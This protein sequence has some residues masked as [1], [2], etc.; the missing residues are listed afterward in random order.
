MTNYDILRNKVYAGL[1]KRYGEITKEIQ[2][3]TDYEL[4][5][6]HDMGFD[7]Y[8]LILDRVRNTCIDKEYIKDF[9][10]RKGFKVPKT[11]YINMSIFGRGSGIGTMIAYGLNLS[12][13]DPIKYDLYFDRFLNKERVSMPDFDY[14][15]SR[16]DRQLLI[17]VLN[18][19]FPYVANIGTT[20][21]MGVK[22]CIKDIG[23]VLGVP[24]QYTNSV[25]KKLSDTDGYE[26]FLNNESV[27]SEFLNIPNVDH[28]FYLKAIQRINGLGK[29]NGIHAGGIVLCGE[30]ISSYI[31][32]RF[33]GER[34]ITEVDMH[35]VE[36]VGFVKNDFLGL[37]TLDVLSECEMVT[38]VSCFD[39][40]QNFDDVDVYYDLRNGKTLGVFQFEGD[41][42]TKLLKDFNVSNFEDLALCNALYR[43]SGLDNVFD[44]KTMLQHAIDRK[45]KKEAIIYLFPEEEQYLSYTYGLMVYQEQIMRRVQQMTGCSLGKADIFRR[46]VGKKD[47]KLLAEQLDWFVDKAMNYRF[48]NSSTWDNETWRKQIVLQVMEDIKACGRYCFN[49]SHAC[50][51]SAI[52]Y[53][54]AYYAHYYPEVFYSAMLNYEDNKDGLTMELAKLKT[55]GFII[56]SPNVNKSELDFT[57]LGHHTI[58]FGLASIKNM[59]KSAEAILEDR[60]KR[61]E[62]SSLYDFAFRL[63]PSECDK[64]TLVSL[65]KAGAFDTICNMDRCS[66]VASMDNFCKMR[67]NRMKVFHRKA[68][69]YRAT[70]EELIDMVNRN[71]KKIKYEEVYDEDTATKRAYFENEVLGYF[72][73]CTPLDD[74]KQEMKYYNCAI[75]EPDHIPPEAYYVGIISSVREITIKNGRS[76]GKKMC[77][78]TLATDGYSYDVT[79]FNGIYESDY[80][81]ITQGNVVVVRG[82][83][84]EYNGKVS[85]VAE[86][87]RTVDIKGVR[88]IDELHLY[89]NIPLNPLQLNAL[90]SGL[91]ISGVGSTRLLLHIPVGNNDISVYV[92]EIIVNNY[93][94]KLMSKIGKIFYGELNS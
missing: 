90:K 7:D 35:F 22:G 66:L 69:D 59:G 3:R 60:E 14:D 33:D 74:Y 62:Y 19:L 91:R 49:K 23:K 77:F 34:L 88:L 10:K 42:T 68:G 29:S 45:N 18:E 16:K 85:I 80:E 12:C 75:V 47:E 54:C 36:D 15:V 11:E 2:E 72:L 56:S 82:K 31:P 93:T 27:M 9:C 38:G 50:G 58:A 40:T 17:E 30:D 37:K 52:G 26:D 87:V 20:G 61:G 63:K 25:A 83:R 64:S 67:T 13:I 76:A 81:H 4:G 6:I 55:M 1:E 84:N 73:S 51:Y 32:C 57:P 79:C 44:G 65:A 46:A 71:D 89:L 39:I 24:F 53:C 92:G 70:Y 48:T 8:F 78:L 43:P 86:Y 21:T 5:V 28:D 41:G 94:L